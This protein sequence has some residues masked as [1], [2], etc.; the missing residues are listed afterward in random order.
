MTD[1]FRRKV[2]GVIKLLAVLFVLSFVPS[3]GFGE[4]NR[5]WD[6]PPLPPP[7]DYG[8]IIID[9]ISTDNNI[10]PVFFSHWR[11]RIKYTC[12]VCHFE[13][14]FAF[15]RGETEITEED[16][17]NGLFCGT[18]HD[19][20]TAFGH[21]KKNCDKCHAGRIIPHEKEY[22]DFT[23]KVRRAPFGNKVDWVGALQS[24]KINPAYSIFNKSE[25]PLKFDK[26]LTLQ[27]AWNYV[28]PAYF[29][30]KTHTDWLD[31]SN[32]HPDIFN[33]KKKTT[34]HFSMEYILENKFCGVCHLRVALPLDDCASC[35]P[36][37]KRK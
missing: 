10:K 4:G 6:F 28:P 19:G 33:V 17:R 27:A 37:I 35:H 12:R 13:L 29:D 14:D 21:I 1:I 15:S 30:H 7:Q 24:G 22:I 23:M 9:R 32:C 26:K 3:I 34:E 18:C 20:T 5:Y 8:D 36:A 25:K 2:S 11:H 31:C 16:N